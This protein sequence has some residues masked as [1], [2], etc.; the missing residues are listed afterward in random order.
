MYENKYKR[1][2]NLFITQHSGHLHLKTGQTILQE[3]KNI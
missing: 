3:L 2:I 1:I